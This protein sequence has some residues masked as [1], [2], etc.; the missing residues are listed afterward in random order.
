MRQEAQSFRALRHDRQR[1]GMVLGLV[2]AN[3]LLGRAR[4]ESTRTG[5]GPLPGFARRL[6]VRSATVVSHVL[7][8]ELG[9]AGRT[10]RHDRFPVREKLWQ[11]GAARQANR[12]A[13]VT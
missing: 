2:R 6:L 9:Q 12:A 7:L 1:L 4:Q 13:T 10:Q 3:V 5:E 8:P 11:S